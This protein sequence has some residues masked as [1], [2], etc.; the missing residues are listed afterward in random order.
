MARL[1]GNTATK[2]DH[3]KFL[4]RITFNSWRVKSRLVSR[5]EEDARDKKR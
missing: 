5:T 4:A 2:T 1:A 3:G